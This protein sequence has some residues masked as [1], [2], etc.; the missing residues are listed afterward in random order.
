MKKKLIFV[1]AVVGLILSSMNV[2]AV[3]SEKIRINVLVDDKP[4]IK[5]NMFLI[6]KKG[7]LKIDDVA[8]IFDAKLKPGKRPG[9]KSLGLEKGKVIF[10]VDSPYVI[11]NWVRRKMNKSTVMINNNIWVPLEGILSSAFVAIA[12]RTVTWNYSNKLLRII[13]R[14]GKRGEEQETEEEIMTVVNI[15]DV[16]VYPHLNYTRTVIRLSEDLTYK[17]TRIEDKKLYIRVNKGSVDTESGTFTI[18][19]SIVEEVV[20]LQETDSA[21]IELR[22]GKD[23]GGHIIEKKE[24]PLRIVIDVKKTREKEEIVAA[25]KSARKKIKTIVIDPGHGGKDPGAI[26]P[27]GVKEKNIVLEIAR[28]LARYLTNNLN[29]RVIM[30]RTSDIFIP[31]AQRTEIA[32]QKKADL[33]ISIHANASLRKSTRGFEI[34]FLSERATDDEAQAV[35]NIENSVLGLEEGYEKSSD[36]YKILRDMRINEYVN[37]SSEACSFIS[38]SVSK[39]GGLINRGVKQAG[40]HVLRGAQMPAVLIETAFISNPAEERELRK[41]GFQYMMAKIIYEGIKDYKSWAER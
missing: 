34:Y 10:T 13:S 39:K 11:I 1:I 4:G 24:R 27:K 23:A 35:A 21:L 32:N 15:T 33:F 20:S 2:C 22:L 40:F 14:S 41:R 7:Y 6:E 26:G 37:E 16:I 5:I 28:Q 12:G 18:E 38:K 8:G 25:I 3:E 19:D 29:C 31:L 30:T 9:Q 17:A 36:L